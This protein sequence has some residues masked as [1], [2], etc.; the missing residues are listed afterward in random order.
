M[1]EGHNAISPGPDDKFTFAHNADGGRM[2]SFNPCACAW[3]IIN[4]LAL[5]WA[6]TNANRK[7]RPSTISHCQTGS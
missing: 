1:G 4:V 3:H 2:K 6:A 7:I 5:A